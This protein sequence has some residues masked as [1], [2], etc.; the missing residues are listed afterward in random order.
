MNGPAVLATA[1]LVA[2]CGSGADV[3]STAPLGSTNAFFAGGRPSRE[4][5][6]TV[7]TIT[8]L[9][10][11]AGF[12]YDMTDG[13]R[14]T[15]I[16]REP[17]GHV[18]AGKTYRLVVDYAG[19]APDASGILVFDGERLLFAAVTDQTAFRRVLRNGIPGFTVAAA[20]SPCASRDRTKCHEA[21]VNL[22]LVFE[23]GGARTAL[24]QGQAARAGDFEIRVLTAQKVRY[25]SRC[26]DAGLPG[27]SFTI[28]RAD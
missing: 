1:M 24:Y 26:A 6:A 10:D 23:H 21:M 4:V 27:V 14:L 17:L 9:E 15:W 18:E 3:C 28:T 12:R 13:T 25:S 7:A 2:S 16:A 20:E 11:P 19:G 8:P 22:P 5:T